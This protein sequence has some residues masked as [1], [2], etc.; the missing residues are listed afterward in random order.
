MDGNGRWAN[1]RGL[2]RIA[3][4]RA[5]TDNIKPI[6][7]ACVEFGVKILT[8]YAFSTE[9]WDRPPDEVRGLLGLLGEVIRR[10]TQNLH[11]NG[12]RV[13]HIGRTE[14]LA[15]ALLQS[16]ERSVELTRNNTRITLNVAFN[17]GGRAEIVDA[18]RT[19]IRN[20]V[21]PE[22]VTEDV[23]ASNLYT[24]SQPDPDLIIRTGGD[25]RL[26]N[27]LLWQAAYAEYYTTP[28]YWPEFNR[29]ALYE[30]LHAY[31]SRDRRFGRVP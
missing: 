10:E 28:L 16:I 26:S 30:A 1:A 23:F 29:E 3:G 22:E 18:A 5:G 12:V 8:I 20:G 9:N 6:L 4:H 24:A 15:P 31:Q 19:L 11:K 13:R 21:R 14:G 27:F 2:P 7:E 17:Y 25:M